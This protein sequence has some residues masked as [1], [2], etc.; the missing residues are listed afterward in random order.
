MKANEKKD[1]WKYVIFGVG[2][3]ATALFMA[4]LTAILAIETVSEMVFGG[5]MAVASCYMAS[6]YIEST[7]IRGEVQNNLLKGLGVGLATN[8]VAIGIVLY[9]FGSKD[10]YWGMFI[11]SAIFAIS[12]LYINYVML[13]IIIPSLDEDDAD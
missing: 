13:Y 2:T 12:G 4:S 1:I 11:S 9:M 3:A 5:F 8:I 7:K 6:R 10:I